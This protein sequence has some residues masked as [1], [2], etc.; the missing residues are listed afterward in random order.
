MPIRQEGG[1]PAARHYYNDVV[2]LFHRLKPMATILFM[3]DGM[4]G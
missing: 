3:P 4:N 1:R 2:N